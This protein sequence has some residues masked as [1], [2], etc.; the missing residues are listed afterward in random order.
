MLISLAS[1][2]AGF[3]MK[4]QLKDYLTQQGHTVIDRGP[5]S[6][7]RVDYPDFAQVVAH[8]V[9]H[10]Q[11]ER[12]IL[13][14]GTGIGMAICANKVPGIRAANVI[15]PQFAV[16]CREHNDA[17]II[18]LSGRFVDAETNIQIVD[19]FLNTDFAGGRHSGRVEK[20]MAL[21]ALTPDAP[22]VP[23]HDAPQGK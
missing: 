9:A 15:N 10:H 21:D 1:D 18:T 20:M 23:A 14:C 5:S 12:G 13:V 22:D 11:A 2:H 17:N 3:D 7:A 19:A 4:Q 6:D 8:D 16:L